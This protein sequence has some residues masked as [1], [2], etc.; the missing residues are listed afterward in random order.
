MQVT[1]LREKRRGAITNAEEW[2]AFWS[3]VTANRSPA[4]APPAVD[5]HQNMVMIAALGPR[6]S[7]GYL[8]SIDEVTS[9]EVAS[10]L[11]IRIREE[12][13]G[14]TCLVCAAVTSPVDAVVVARS[15]YQLRF[16]QDERVYDCD[17]R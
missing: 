7:C 5:F 6:S 12:S 9:D 11:E 13:P 16:F 15:N 17:C 1:A 2:L 10:F 4:R 8:V 3:E 14:R